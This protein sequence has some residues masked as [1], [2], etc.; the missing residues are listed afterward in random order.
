MKA[1][2]FFAKM[3][4]AKPQNTAMKKKSNFA[5]PCALSLLRDIGYEMRKIRKEYRISMEK[6]LVKRQEKM[7]G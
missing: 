1:L 4:Y 3:R 6:E 7:G 5:Q 2:Y